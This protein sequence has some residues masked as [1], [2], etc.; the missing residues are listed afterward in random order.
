[1]QLLTGFVLSCLTFGEMI[2]KDSARHTT[3][4]G[5][6]DAVAVELLHFST[7]DETWLESVRGYLG[8]ISLDLG[9]LR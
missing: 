1:M 3:E 2:G 5:D 6:L 4:E 8:H 7:D 9:D